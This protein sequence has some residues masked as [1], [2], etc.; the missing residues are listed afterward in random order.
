MNHLFDFIKKKK[1]YFLYAIAVVILVVG[2]FFLFK[3]GKDDGSTIIVSYSDFINQVSISGNVI[4]NQEV[5]L[6]FQNSGIIK[7]VFFTVGE[8]GS[9]VKTGTIIAELDTK[10][11]EKEIHDAEVALESAKLSLEKLKLTNSNKNLVADLEQAYDDGFNAVSNAFLDLSK[12]ITGLK[13]VLDNNNLSDNSARMSGTMAVNSRNKAEEL[14][15]QALKV[16]KANNINFRLLNRNSSD[17]MV[18]VSLGETYQTTKI[19]AD[20]LRSAKN[21]VDYFIED[22]N[23]DSNFTPLQTTLAQHIDTINGHL[24]SL[25]SAKNNI[26]NYE[27]AFSDTDLDIRDLELT[28]K[29]KENNL[30]DARNKLLDY[31]I[32]AP[33]NGVITKVDAKV[34]E[35]ASAN[36][37]LVSMISAGTF[38]IESYVP[39][40][41]IALI[42]VGN[43][44][45]VTLDAYGEKVLFYAKVVSIDPAETIR[46]GVSTYKIKLQFNE[47]DNRI[48]KGMTANVSVLIFNKLN[49][50]ALP[51]GVVFD[52]NGKKYV[53]IKNKKEIIDREVTLGV[54]S[55]LGQVEIISGL[56]DGDKVILNPL[57]SSL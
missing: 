53:K 45:E 30:Q 14:Y 4:A 47:E 42:K 51:G 34:G 15:H 28:I 49:V 52:K 6:G 36:K 22:S 55:P 38:L 54:A 35:L 41:N 33:F 13:D 25:F 9:A 12:I 2:G 23:D 19:V 48:R 20:A 32:R 46:D 43:E 57:N 29:Q 3:N 5:D 18:L 11:V 24:S 27:E 10:D 21:L 44:A 31:R 56:K 40:V 16:F 8:G 37:S 17:E 26:N 7:R 50:I 1:I 39:E